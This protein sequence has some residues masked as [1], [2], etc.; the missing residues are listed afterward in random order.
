MRHEITTHGHRLNRVYAGTPACPAHIGGRMFS[1]ITPVETVQDSPGSHRPIQK[2]YSPGFRRV[3]EYSLP[4]APLCIMPSPS[5]E[6]SQGIH[7]NLPGFDQLRRPQSATITVEFLLLLLLSSAASI[8]H[9]GNN[10]PNDRGFCCI[11]LLR[12]SS[13]SFEG[14]PQIL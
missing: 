1:C 4:S 5:G 9:N 7:T 3:S 11:L 6:S 10:G 8:G 14:M 2:N 13:A 12:R